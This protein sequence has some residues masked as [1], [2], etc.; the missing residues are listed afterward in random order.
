MQAVKEPVARKAIRYFKSNAP[1]SPLE[2]VGH[3]S[4][5][6]V[7]PAHRTLE[8]CATEYFNGLLSG[9]LECRCAK[10]HD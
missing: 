4:N 10:G 8:T 1:N 5:V 3:V 9:W 2:N 7:F 6:P